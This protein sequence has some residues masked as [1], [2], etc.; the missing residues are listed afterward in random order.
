[1]SFDTWIPGVRLDVFQPKVP[2]QR[3]IGY[4]PYLR[5]DRLDLIFQIY[6][7]VYNYLPNMFHTAI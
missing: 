4:V 2:T 6:I 5:S 7:S 1:M 3:L